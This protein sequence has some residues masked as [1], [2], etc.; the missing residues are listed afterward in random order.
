MPW[1]Y[2][3]SAEHAVSSPRLHALGITALLNVSTTQLPHLDGFVYMTIPVSDNCGSDLAMW[4]TDAIQFIGKFNF[5]LGSFVLELFNVGMKSSNK[6]SGRSF[7]LIC[8]SPVSL[9]PLLNF[10]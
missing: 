7:M 9:V 2:L 1:L 8:F 5:V 4:F 10:T 6:H 3:G